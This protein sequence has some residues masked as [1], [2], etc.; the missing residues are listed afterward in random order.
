MLQLINKMG[1]VSMLAN[2]SQTSAFAAPLP[3]H[4]PSLSDDDSINNEL[5]QNIVPTRSV[6]K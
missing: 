3:P 2:K 6:S 4:L 5:I 1:G